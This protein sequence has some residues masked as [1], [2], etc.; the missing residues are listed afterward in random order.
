MKTTRSSQLAAQAQLHRVVLAAALVAGSLPALGLQAPQALPTAAAASDTPWA[1]LN[2]D[3]K[4]ALAPLNSQWANLTPEHRRKWIEL[5]KNFS[6]LSPD[7]Q[8]RVH[9]RMT[10]WAALSPGE[11]ANA[12]LNF[13]EA[14]TKLNPDERKAKWEAYQA[15]SPQERAN[16]TQ[17]G[18]QSTSKGAAPAL[19]LDTGKLATVPTPKPADPSAAASAP[20]K[21]PKIAVEGTGTS[22]N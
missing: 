5:T 16:L 15:L 2:A 18:Q 9:D 4:R 3:Q 12:R 13:N 20:K 10:G 19:R 17:Q 22:P 1:S 7:Q 14:A 11:R 6:S 21:T 8:A